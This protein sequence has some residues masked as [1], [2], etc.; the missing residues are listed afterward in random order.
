MLVLRA[1]M[2]APLHGY[3]IASKR[4]D[5]ESLPPVR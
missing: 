5:T 2:F 4:I 3:G 1:L